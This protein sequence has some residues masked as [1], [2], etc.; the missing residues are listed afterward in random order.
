[1]VA[2]LKKR[3]LENPAVAEE[4]EAEITEIVAENIKT[5]EETNVNV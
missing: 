2:E 3:V 5:V 1:M 4:M